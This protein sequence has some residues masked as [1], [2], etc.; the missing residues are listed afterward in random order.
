MTMQ[1][2]LVSSFASQPLLIKENNTFTHLGLCGAVLYCISDVL[3]IIN[4]GLK[5]AE[6]AEGRDENR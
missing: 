1:S 4:H 2:L 3:V 6:K 5:N